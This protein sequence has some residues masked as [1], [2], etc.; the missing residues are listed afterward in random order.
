MARRIRPVTWGPGGQSSLATGSARERPDRPRRRTASTSTRRDRRGSTAAP[1]DLGEEFAGKCWPAATRGSQ[2]H[3]D[4]RA[5]APDMTPCLAKYRSEG[6]PP[7]ACRRPCPRWTVTSQC[8]RVT[9]TERRGAS[10]TP[11]TPTGC[12]T[13]RPGSRGAVPK[14]QTASRTR[15]SWRSSASG[16]CAIRTRCGRGCTRSC[17]A[18]RIATTG[19][20]TG[21]RCRPWPGRRS[22][23]AT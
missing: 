8:E 1:E 18:R 19:A 10:C 22:T 13:T 11:A 7:P 20:R 14:R 4:R 6:C 2:P 3:E 15:S 9:A 5:P 17:A 16:S 23:V 21:S 12:S